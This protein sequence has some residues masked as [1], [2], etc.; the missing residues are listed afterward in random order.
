MTRNSSNLTNDILRA[1]DIMGELG[2]GLRQGKQGF[3]RCLRN[4]DRR[5]IRQGMYNM[6]RRGLAR[7]RNKS[8]NRVYELTDLGR[9]KLLKENFRKLSKQKR[10]DNLSTV[11]IFDIPETM[12]RSRDFLRRLLLQNDF[13][14][15]Q[16]SVF[17]G[18][19]R[20][21]VDEMMEILKELKI[22]HN[23]TLMEARIITNAK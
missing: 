13:I 19:Y 18:P 2:V 4:Y 20:V 22:E 17:I 15:L 12:H 10:S 11:I 8:K 6:E 16:E 9:A 3:I 21:P 7:S 1:M 23:V 14:C 5:Q